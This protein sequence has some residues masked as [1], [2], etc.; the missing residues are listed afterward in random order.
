MWITVNM[1]QWVKGFPKN[2]IERD[3]RILEMEGTAQPY[4][5]TAIGNSGQTITTKEQFY[6]IDLQKEI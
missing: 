4:Y 1:Y 5:A 3:G 6:I 2:P